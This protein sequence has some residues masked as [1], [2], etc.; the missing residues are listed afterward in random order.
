MS[1]SPDRLKADSPKVV[2]VM[3]AYNAGRTLRMTYE[4]LPKEAVA[5]VIVVDDGSTDATLEIARDLNVEI[6]VHNRNYGYGANQKTC[7]T[8]ALKAGAGIVVMVHPDYQYDPTLLPQIVEPITKGEADLVLGSRLMAGSAVR[9]GMPWWKFAGNRVLS[10]LENRVFGLSLS[11]LHTGY[12]AFRR[13]VLETVNFQMNSDGFVFDQEI[14]AQVVAA[15]YRIA[16]IAVPVRYFPEAS[17]ASF[18]DSVVYGL[19]ILLLLVRFALY[20][21]GLYRSRRFDSLRARYS[22]L[23]PGD[24]RPQ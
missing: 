11:E 9:Q 24:T 14:I 8:E 17:S 13:E 10:W 16:E 4:E 15:R 22:R 7:Y 21:S 5:L 6:F 3:P 1:G 19:K 23:G 2:V 12:R 18:T 20:R